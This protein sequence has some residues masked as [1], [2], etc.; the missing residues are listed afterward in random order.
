MYSQII[1]IILVL[2]VLIMVV[3]SGVFTQHEP[4]SQVI[5]PGFSNRKLIVSDTIDGR[6]EF[7][8]KESQ[9]YSRYTT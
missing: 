2:L 4:F 3:Q 8:K 5:N 6:Y 7:E 1:S 9:F